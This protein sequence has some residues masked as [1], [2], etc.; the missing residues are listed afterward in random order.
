M[1][2]DKLAKNIDEIYEKHL[3][4]YK[5]SLSDK[6]GVSIPEKWEDRDMLSLLS[7]LLFRSTG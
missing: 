7:F 2:Q 5:K 4:D 1:N 3:A 6:Q